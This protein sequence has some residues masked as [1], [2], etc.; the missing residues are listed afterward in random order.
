MA[1]F[2]FDRKEDPMLLDE[3][4]AGPPPVPWLSLFPYWLGLKAVGAFCFP[5]VEGLFHASFFVLL[6]ALFRC[7]IP[8]FSISFLCAFAFESAIIYRVMMVFSSMFTA[9]GIETKA[10]EKTLT[11]LFHPD[12]LTRV[13]RPVPTLAFL[14]F[15]VGVCARIWTADR[16]RKR[17]AILLGVALSLCLSSY[18]YMAVHLLVLSILVLLFRLTHRPSESRLFW[19]YLPW[20]LLPR[21]IFSHP[22]LLQ[23]V[24]YRSPDAL[25]RLGLYRSRF[26]MMGI[27]PMIGY[28]I[29]VFGVVFLLRTLLASVPRVIDSSVYRVACNP[30]VSF[31]LL[32]VVS[33]PIGMVIQPFLLGGVSIQDGTWF[34]LYC[35][36]ATFAWLSFLVVVI[37]EAW[38][39][40]PKVRALMTAKKNLILPVVLIIFSVLAVRTRVLTASSSGRH[41]W[42]FMEGMNEYKD[43][44]RTYFLEL[45]D[46][47]DR[48][49]P[50]KVVLTFDQ[51][52]KHY[53]STYRGKK[54]Y[55]PDTVNTRV[56]DNEIET[57]FLWAL[58]MLGVRANEL[59]SYLNGPGDLSYFNV[60]SF[61]H[62]KYSVSRR[63]S[64]ESL[65]HYPPD[66]LAATDGW[67]F[68]G[69]NRIACGRDELE[70]LSARFETLDADA[71]TGRALDLIVL[72][73]NKYENR[74]APPS[75]RFEKIW[76]NTAFRVFRRIR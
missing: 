38:L 33:G 51:V 74:F 48:Y 67:T 2:L 61:A 11:G 70:R 64:L 16:I 66:V 3:G 1:R 28:P 36:I 7:F 54:L 43:D 59:A 45:A 76:E 57:R 20:G 50:Y 9:L 18:S 62:Q 68:S 42:F 40:L 12:L 19:Q 22:K 31:N 10:L 75:A 35:Y 58:K 14:L 69:W 53:L 63:S 56:G 32:L 73:K 5:I 41:T 47:L 71:W 6:M 23:I 60:H 52:L 29:V 65:S 26:G 13:T 8:S 72:L 39:A 24:D 34:Q 21:G 44:Y 30:M 46:F 15:G 49:E 17:D 27:S 55:C 4:L 25:V 37:S